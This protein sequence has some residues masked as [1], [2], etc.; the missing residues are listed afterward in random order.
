M[1]ESV[2]RHS[3]RAGRLRRRGEQVEVEQLTLDEASTGYDQHFTSA[4]SRPVR[5]LAEFTKSIREQES[6][7]QEGSM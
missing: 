1:P 3:G 5:S 7:P 6:S 4:P 2:K